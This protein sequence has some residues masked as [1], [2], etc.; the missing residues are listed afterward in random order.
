MRRFGFPDHLYARVTSLLKEIGYSWDKPGVLA[1]EVRRL[2]DFYISNPSGATPWAERWAQAAYLAYYLPLNFARASAVAHEAH[3]RGFF[4]GLSTLIDFGAGPGTAQMAISDR[5]TGLTTSICIDRSREPLELHK[6]LLEGSTQNIAWRTET[7]PE[8]LPR[9]DTRLAVFS[10]AAT[11]LERLPSWATESEAILLIEPSTREDGRALLRTRSALLTS[12]YHAWAPCSHQGPCP[13]LDSSERDWCHDRI[14]WDAPPGWDALEREL[15]MKN[16]TLTYSYVLLRK[17]P[18]PTTR[19]HLAR[20]IGDPLV[21]KGKTRQLI[22]QGPSREFLAWFP[23]RMKG[24]TPDL[25]R[26]DLIELSPDLT[27]K[28]NE[29][30]LRETDLDL[31][32]LEAPDSDN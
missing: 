15:P 3:T 12:G 21:E 17:T 4:S 10:Y 20:V 26:G 23:Q 25:N 19:P 8:S 16:R 22:C 29:I 11:E 5:F 9:R 6:R 28:A 27:I 14:E 7:S 24:R 32:K 2:S 1:A 13:L 31:R 30:R 18:P